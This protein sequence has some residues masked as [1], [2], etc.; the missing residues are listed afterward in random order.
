[1]EKQIIEVDSDLIARCGLYC[2]AC[3]KYLAKKCPGCQKNE[4]ASWCKIRAC[5]A[6]KGYHSCA[7]CPMDVKECKTFSNFIG[8]VFALLFGSDRNACIRRIREIGKEAFAAEMAEKR[9][10]TIKNR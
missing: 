10:Q 5:N 2:G 7:D 4:K 8:K 3:H 6:E 1:M 9:Q